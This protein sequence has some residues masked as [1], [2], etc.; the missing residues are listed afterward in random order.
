MD[1]VA[2]EVVASEVVALEVAGKD[3][4][5]YLLQ[6]ISMRFARCLR[7]CMQPTDSCL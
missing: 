4:K 5:L 1:S 7:H 3:L 6:A 2:S